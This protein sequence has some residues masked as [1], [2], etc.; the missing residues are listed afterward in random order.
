LKLPPLAALGVIAYGLPATL[1]VD[2]APKLDCATVA[3]VSP[4]CS[5]L[6]L[7]AVDDSVT[8]WP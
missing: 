3:I 1:A 6:A 4:F 5:P 2:A 8:V 7:N